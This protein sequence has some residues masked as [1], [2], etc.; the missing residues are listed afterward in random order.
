MISPQEMDKVPFLRDLGGP[1]ADQIAHI[2]ELREYPA[3]DT[4]FCQGQDFPFLCVVLNGEVSLD[5]AVSGFEVAEVH[6]GGPGDLLGWSPVLGRRSMTATARAATP[7]RLAVVPID[8]V[9]ALCERDGRFGTA[10]HRQM[11]LVL[12][13]RLDETRRRLSQYLTRRAH[14]ATPEGS[15]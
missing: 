5:M 7:L 14:R 11:A 12:S 2:A 8:Q 3:G 9:L 10:F 15:D 1:C 4:I 6:R 13:S